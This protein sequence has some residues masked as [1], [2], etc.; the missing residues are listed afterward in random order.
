MK[1]YIDREDPNPK[2]HKA[3]STEEEREEERLTSLLFSGAGPL[4]VSDESNEQ[5][6][7]DFNSDRIQQGLF[8]Y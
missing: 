7:L 8:I 5:H 1:R 3:L 2:K 6:R 4:L